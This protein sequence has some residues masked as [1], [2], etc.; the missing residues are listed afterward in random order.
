VVGTRVG[1]AIDGAR[2]SAVALRGN[3]TVWAAEAAYTGSA[4]LER[5]LG[6]L[7]AERPRN[8]RIA[9]V[10]LGPDVTRLK[11]VEGLPRLE[12]A[13]LAAH[14]R[15]HSRRYFL[16]NGVALVTDAVPAHRNGSDGLALL[17]AA[18]VPII[19]AVSRGL[20]AAGLRCDTITPLALLTVT[21]DDQYAGA[22]AAAT[23]RYA[24]LLLVPDH[25]RAARLAAQVVTLRRWA[26]AGGAS[27][28]LA[29]ATWAVKT[30]RAERAS[31]AELLRL[32]PMVSA[33][34]RVRADLDAATD[35]LGVLGRAGAG[36]SRRARFLADLTRAL[37][38]SVFLVSLRLDP[39]QTGALAGFAS[40]AAPVIARLEQAGL[41]RHAAFEGPVTREALGGREW[42]RFAIRF[43][44]PSG[45]SPR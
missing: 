5:V 30:V 11:T 4:D 43:R 32:K 3:R 9:T 34:L 23:A 12:H 33:A 6:Q 41:V 16:Q 15:L 8:A 42:E 22:R 2:V 21:G 39:D 17:A 25:A 37:P 29:A 36:R 26:F 45:E 31:A 14:V 40:H 18:P 1:I 35:A 7:A 24:Q 28:L 27:V 38:D 10:A 13:D 44:F 20:E 19:D